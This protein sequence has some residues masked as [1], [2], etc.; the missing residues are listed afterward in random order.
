MPERDRDSR[1][2]RAREAIAAKLR[3]LLGHARREAVVG[4]GILGAGARYWVRWCHSGVRAI[5]GEHHGVGFDAV[6]SRVRAANACPRSSMVKRSMKWHSN[7]VLAGPVQRVNARP[8]RAYHLVGDALRSD[9][10]AVSPARQHGS[11]MSGIFRVARSRSA[12][13][14]ARGAARLRPRSTWRSRCAAAPYRPSP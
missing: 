6:R 14:G 3:P 7:Q 5:D 9:E 4:G 8:G 11:F 12:P 2:F 10:L 1:I 13:A